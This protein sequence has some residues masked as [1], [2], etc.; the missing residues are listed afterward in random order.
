MPSIELNYTNKN[1][2]DD[3]TNHTQKYY[4]ALAFTMPLILIILMLSY[5]HI[6]T[7]IINC[8]KKSLTKKTEPV[9]KDK[10]LHIENIK[11]LKLKKSNKEVCPICIEKFKNGQKIISLE[12]NH[13]FHKDCIV[14]WIT[15]NIKSHNHADC[16]SC[17]SSIK[18]KYKHNLN[19]NVQ[20]FII[21]ITLD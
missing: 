17:R 11:E 5:L 13:Q 4:D 3:D 21:K 14:S 20:G 7:K 1:N 18:H 9:K 2:D 12:C 16:P 19:K 15:Q 10:E 6:K 8:K